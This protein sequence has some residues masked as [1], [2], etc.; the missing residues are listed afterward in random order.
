MNRN[1]PIVEDL[2]ASDFTLHSRRPMTTLNDFGGVVDTF[3][4]ALP[5]SW[6]RILARMFEAAL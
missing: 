3:F 1:S 5:I 2:F 4:W 6:S